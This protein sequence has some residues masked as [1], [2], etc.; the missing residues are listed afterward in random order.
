MPSTTTRKCPQCGQ[1]ESRPIAA[2]AKQHIVRCKSCGFVYTG[3]EPT[4][5]ELVA[6]YEHYPAP[7]TISPITIT[8]YDELLKRFAP[9]RKMGRLFE[10]GCGA[11]HFL[12]R[13][14]MQEWDVQ[15]NEYGELTMKACR[16]RGIPVTEGKLDPDAHELGSYD[17]VCSFE[18]IEHVIHPRIEIKNMLA[19]LRPGGLLYLT[20]P[21]YN[22]LA[23]MIAPG[24][25]SVA[26]YPEHLNYF[27]SRTMSKMAGSEGA[28][29]KWLTTTGVS[30]ERW[31]TKQN[32]TPEDHIAAHLVQEDLRARMETETT[33]KIFKRVANS[34][35]DLIKVGDSMKA[36]FEKPLQ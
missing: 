3:W 30:V 5:Q 16:D 6:Y 22:S 4:E 7:S 31:R 15:G 33:M 11:G 9:Y 2:L 29:K 35:L 12:E 8:R 14:K 23:R 28:R 21:N 26:S 19:L 10:V 32:R 36:G 25:W 1:I 13:A 18:V 20:T 17:I 24:E 34:I 27:T